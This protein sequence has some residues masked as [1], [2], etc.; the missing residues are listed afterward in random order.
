[1]LTFLVDLVDVLEVIQ[2]L[3]KYSHF[4]NCN[5]QMDYTKLPLERASQTE[6]R[7]RQTEG[8]G[9]EITPWIL[10]GANVH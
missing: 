10:S 7:A 1:M 9:C 3:K 6:R 5:R 4:H 2:V 8:N